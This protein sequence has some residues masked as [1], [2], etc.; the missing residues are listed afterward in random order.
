MGMNLMLLNLTPPRIVRPLVAT[1][2]NERAGVVSPDG[3]W[4]A[5]ESDSS[6][7][8]QI[9]VRPFPRTEAGQWEVSIDGGRGARWARSGREL[10]YRAGD[11][12][13]RSV[14]VVPRGQEWWS[15]TPEKVLEQ[16]YLVGLDPGRNYDISPDGQRLLL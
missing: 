3:R 11:G 16:Q 12:T 8:Y 1:P 7:R 2:F 14:S 9:Y 13:F 15:G 4:L 5:Y 10:I 6:G